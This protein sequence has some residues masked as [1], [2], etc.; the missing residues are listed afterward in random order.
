VPQTVK[1]PAAPA[2]TAAAGSIAAADPSHVGNSSISQPQYKVPSAAPPKPGSK[3]AKSAA[4]AAAAAAAQ[5]PAA[6]AAAVPAE[7]EPMSL[8]GEQGLQKLLSRHLLL[9]VRLLVIGWGYQQ[10]VL[11]SEYIMLNQYHAA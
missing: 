10:L 8:A 3:A 4:A 2:A 11:S 5:A 9:W 1:A 7:S 6:V